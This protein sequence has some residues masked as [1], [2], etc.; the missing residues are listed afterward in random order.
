MARTRGI[1]DR[2]KRVP[3]GVA[4]KKL[5]ID[6]GT[7][8][9]LKAEN[10]VPRWINED[11]MRL[12]NAQ[13]GGYEFVES[14]GVE[15]VGG[16]KQEQDRRIRKAVGK[17]ANGQPKY[18]YLM[19]I[20]KEF[21]EEDQQKKEGVNKKVDDAIRGGNPVGLQAHGIDPEKGR[22]TVNKIDYQP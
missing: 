22:T 3:F 4:R 15:I 7:S 12:M 13:E 14:A 9:R 17:H 1:E 18:A 19:A 16:E 6:R 10:K 5:D 8:A 21:Y 11:D 20:P 2:T